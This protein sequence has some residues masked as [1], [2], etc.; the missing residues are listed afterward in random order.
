MVK[1]VMRQNYSHEPEL[2]GS[3]WLRYIVF[4]CVI[5]VLLM[6][7]V[8]ARLVQVMVEDLDWLRQ[9]VPPVADLIVLAALVV[10]CMKTLTIWR[11]SET[12]PKRRDIRGRVLILLGSIWFLFIL[13]MYIA[14][15]LRFLGVAA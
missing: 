14:P 2:P 15:V 9:A 10:F 3:E 1:Q 13:T 4:A 7:F 6:L 11:K 5:Q 8:I 12:H